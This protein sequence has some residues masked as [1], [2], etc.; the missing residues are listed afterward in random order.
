MNRGAMST[1]RSRL[2]A[3]ALPIL[4][5]VAACG[6][7]AGEPPLAGAAIGGV[8][9]RWLSAEPSAPVVGEDKTK[10]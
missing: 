4:L 5:F 2:R 6:A 7:P 1:V 3:L 10:G 8:T 9:Y